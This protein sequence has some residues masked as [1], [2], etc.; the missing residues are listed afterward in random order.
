MGNREALAI[1]IALNNYLCNCNCKPGN[2]NN[3]LNNFYVCNVSVDDGSSPRRLFNWENLHR[4]LQNK[5][6]HPTFSDPP[7]EPGR[8]R[9][10]FKPVKASS[11]GH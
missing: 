8:T 10:L 7:E 2:K 9:G 5:D 3:S 6:L 11:L 4:G 1:I